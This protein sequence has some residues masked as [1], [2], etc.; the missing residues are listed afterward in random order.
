[1]PFQ[2]WMAL[3]FT[4]CYYSAKSVGVVWLFVLSFVLSVSS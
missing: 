4:E 1:M 2:F 3:N